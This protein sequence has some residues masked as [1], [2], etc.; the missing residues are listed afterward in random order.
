MKKI[1]MMPIGIIKTRFETKANIPI[2]PTSG[3]GEQGNIEIFDEYLPAL[4]GLD[5]FSHIILLYYFHKADNLKLKARPFMDET[6]RGIFSIRAPIRPNK[7]GMSIVRLIKIEKNVLLVED[8]DILNNTPLLDIKPY[9][10]EFD[11][12]ADAN[13]GWISKSQNEINAFKSDDRFGK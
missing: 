8:I 10:P 6:E 1:T 2:Q 12:K 5:S 7:I 9:V 11:I 4:E 3:I 13:S